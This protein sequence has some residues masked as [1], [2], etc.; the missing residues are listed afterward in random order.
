MTVVRWVIG[1]HSRMDWRT[2]FALVVMLYP[3][4]G[5]MGLGALLMWAGLDTLAQVVMWL[6]ILWVVMVCAALP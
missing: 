4:L 5:A 1:L 6:A 3:L 2:S